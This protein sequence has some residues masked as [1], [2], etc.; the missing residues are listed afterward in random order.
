M[1]RTYKMTSSLLKQVRKFDNG[2]DTYKERSEFISN[3]YENVDCIGESAM[4]NSEIARTIE[5]QATYLLNGKD[6][7]SGR[8]QEY[9]Y[10]RN[11]SDYRSN[12]SVGGNTISTDFGE[13]EDLHETYDPNEN[14]NII[15]DN[16]NSLFYLD[17]MSIE[18]KKRLIKIGL[19]EKDNELND[20]SYLMM[21]LYEYILDT[22][23]DD[24]D[25]KVVEFCSKG[26]TELEIA[27]MIGVSRRSV[28]KRINRICEKK[29]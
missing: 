29:I 25:R 4:E 19:K 18:E 11:E 6:V 22:L 8:K 28:N 14:L 9:S 7:E 13:R 12:Y 3:I 5:E 2:L 21:E 23:D 26:L 20:L 15:I 1:R 27:S 17:K 24:V 10:Y 16:V